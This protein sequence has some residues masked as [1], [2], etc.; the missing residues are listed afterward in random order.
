MRMRV[1]DYLIPLVISILILVVFNTLSTTLFPAFGFINFR[2]SFSILIILFLAFKI[3]SPFVPIMIL[4]IQVFHGAFT[5]EGWAF[6][7]FAG[8]L[9]CIAIRYVKELLD[10][11]S[12]LSTMMVVQIF[13]LVW[14]LLISILIYVRIGELSYILNR[15]YYF[16]LESIMLSLIAPFLFVL[17]DRVWRVQNQ[18]EVEV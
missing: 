13:Q 12:A 9:V 17:L 5:V 7:T 4:T 3:E 14:F 2:P 16:F 6:G 10:F 8:V 18:G 11:S 1:S 15:F